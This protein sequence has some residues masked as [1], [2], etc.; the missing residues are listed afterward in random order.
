MV[1]MFLIGRILH[2]FFGP[3]CPKCG[4]PR[5]GM[6]PVEQSYTLRVG[7]ALR[8]CA[9]GYE[10]QTGYR[11]WATLSD[12]EKNAYI[13][14]TAEIVTLVLFTVP[15]FV[16]GYFVEFRIGH[17]WKSAF[18]TLGWGALVGVPIVA[19]SWTTKFLIVRRSLRRVPLADPLLTGQPLQP[20]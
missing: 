16:L 13:F 7:Q 17:P 12:S 11:E 4:R 18:I 14:S 6:A 2:Y 9:C 10:Y 19:V 1:E 8:Q 3:K 15:L 20:R 5:R